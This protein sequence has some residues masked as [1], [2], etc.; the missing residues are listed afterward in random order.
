MRS[1]SEV[2]S[3]VIAESKWIPASALR[4]V[5][6]RLRAAAIDR[7][8]G[9]ETL[10][11]HDLPVPELDSEEV[12]IEVRAA[13]V[14]PWDVDMRQ[15]WWP[16]GEPTFPLVLGSDGAGRVARLGSRVR[17]FQVGQSSHWRRQ[18]GPPPV[19]RLATCWARSSC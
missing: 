8:G 17:R 13:G 16:E 5:P 14:G 12:L 3:N 9:P 7:F 4:P 15:G 6:E 19:W 2:P 18:P 10:T 1:D 11:L